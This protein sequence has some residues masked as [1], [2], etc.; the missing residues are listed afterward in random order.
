MAP[1][2]AR[3]TGSRNLSGAAG[4][5]G[6]LAQAHAARTHRS[7]VPRCGAG[8]PVTDGSARPGVPLSQG[9]HP[10][11]HRRPPARAAPSGPWAQQLPDPRLAE[12]GPAHTRAGKE[13]Q[14]HPQH[15]RQERPPVAPG[16]N[17][18][19]HQTVEKGGWGRLQPLDNPLIRGALLAGGGGF[20]D[21]LITLPVRSKPRGPPAGMGLEAD[22]LGSSLWLGAPGEDLLP[23]WYRPSSLPV[24]TLQALD[25]RVATG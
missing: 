3:Y 19:D 20:F 8:P 17:W 1:Q 7:R 16:S 5:R 18:Y 24:H 4:T 9:S 15:A 14:A 13:S 21:S 10:S 22:F 25:E 2:G 23:W 11:Q 12:P 6:L